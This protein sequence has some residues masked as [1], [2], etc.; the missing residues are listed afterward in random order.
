MIHD[1]APPAVM[2]AEVSVFT[3]VE[4]AKLRLPSRG[5]TPA[6]MRDDTV[7][8]VVNL[9]ARIME[10][11]T[12]ISFLR[13]QKERFIEAANLLEGDPADQQAGANG[14]VDAPRMGVVPTEIVAGPPE[15]A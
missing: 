7:W 8:C 3:G 13:V 6:E 14:E 4:L 2:L 11:V 9:P 15:E 1:Q 12:K 10:P 5:A